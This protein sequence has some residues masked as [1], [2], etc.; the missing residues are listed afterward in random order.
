ML[1][2]NVGRIICTTRGSP[3]PN[4]KRG[5]TS[6]IGPSGYF[7]SIAQRH[8]QIFASTLLISLLRLE[9]AESNSPEER[10]RSIDEINKSI[11]DHIRPAVNNSTKRQAAQLEAAVPW[12]WTGQPF[13]IGS[14][15]QLAVASPK[16]FCKLLVP[17][18]LRP[19]CSLLAKPMVVF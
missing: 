6:P 1:K 5:A 13:P 11:C 4:K 8:P 15:M 10:R 2:R 12:D 9:I 7:Q 17:A 18:F 16:A 19:P 3:I 14:L